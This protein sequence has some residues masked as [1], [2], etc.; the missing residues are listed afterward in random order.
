M[1]H[2]QSEF[3]HE[4]FCSSYEVSYDKCSEI[5][6][7]IFEASFCGPDQKVP[8]N[9]AFQIVACAAFSS[10]GNDFKSVIAREF[11]LKIDTLLAIATSGSRTNLLLENPPPPRRKPPIR[12]SQAISQEIERRKSAQKIRQN[13]TAFFRGL[14]QEFHQNFALGDYG[15]NS[16]NDFSLQRRYRKDF[17]SKDHD[18]KRRK[19]C[20]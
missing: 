19:T 12:F 16:L 1:A 7:D 2:L 6:P 17:R 3:W 13:F 20:R 15:Q 11:L 4:M 14:L 18:F 5:F 8:Q 10:R 9:S